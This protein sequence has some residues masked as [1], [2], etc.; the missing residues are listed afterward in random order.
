MSK[1]EKI[2]MIQNAVESA[3]LQYDAENVDIV[4]DEVNG[5]VDIVYH[6]KHN[7]FAIVS[8]VCE[9]DGLSVSDIDNVAERYDIGYCW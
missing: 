8:D 1:N 3:L 9:S 5:M 6:S 4:K 2:Q 7:S